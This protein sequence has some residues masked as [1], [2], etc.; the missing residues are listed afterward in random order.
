MSEIR[1]HA[2]L[3]KAGAVMLEF[4]ESFMQ[5]FEKA[6]KRKIC[7][8][9]REHAWLSQTR[10]FGSN[11]GQSAVETSRGEISTNSVNPP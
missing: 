11:K 2:R 6:V 8:G 5:V 10:G 7:L 1:Y 3:V 9:L 4:G